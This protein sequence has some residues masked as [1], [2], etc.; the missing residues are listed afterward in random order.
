MIK[1]INVIV[2]VSFLQPC[3]SNLV[4]RTLA[5]VKTFTLPKCASKLLMHT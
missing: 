5:A 4:V 2:R 1:P 3:K